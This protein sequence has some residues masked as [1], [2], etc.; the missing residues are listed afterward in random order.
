MNNALANADA[1]MAGLFIFIVFFVIVLVW[2]FQPASKEKFKKF[3]EI[4][5]KDE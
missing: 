2:V 4:P 3:G 1:G 5:L